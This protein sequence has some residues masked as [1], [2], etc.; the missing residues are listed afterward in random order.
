M[1]EKMTLTADQMKKIRSARKGNWKAS[2]VEY[3]KTNNG[4]DE[5]SIYDATRPDNRDLPKA[6]KVKNLA[7]QYTYLRDE[8]Y[9]VTKEEDKVFLLVEPGVKKG[10]FNVI[11]G[12]EDRIKRFL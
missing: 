1:S 12:Q 8:G 10:E 2:I 4:S 5:I 11:E 9:L 3:L 7:S 6:K